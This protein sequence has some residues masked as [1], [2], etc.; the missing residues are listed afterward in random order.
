MKNEL[1]DVVEAN[2]IQT[3]VGDCPRCKSEDVGFSRLS[4]G[5][6]RAF[7]TECSNKVEAD[8]ADL[9]SQWRKAA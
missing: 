3:F 6:W 8:P 7:C 9:V 4:G 1:N 2:T 5:A